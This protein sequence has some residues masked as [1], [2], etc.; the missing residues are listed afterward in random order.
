[1]LFGKRAMPLLCGW[2]SWPSGCSQKRRNSCSP[3]NC[4]GLGLRW[5]RTLRKRLVDSL[6]AISC[7][8]CRSPTR[9]RLSRTT[10]SVCSMIREN[11]QTRNSTR[12]SKIVMNSSNSPAASARRW[13]RRTPN[14]KFLIP[15][16]V[17]RPPKW[18]HDKQ[19]GNLNQDQ[20]HLESWK[21][22]SRLDTYI[23]KFYLSL[24]YICC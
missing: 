21:P 10:G 17:S 18:W 7:P 13:E 24:N 9:K 4:F 20:L 5:V 19:S 22:E 14:S 12:S 23:L 1:M 2:W 16:C 3:N 11:F 6:S 8:R 15:D